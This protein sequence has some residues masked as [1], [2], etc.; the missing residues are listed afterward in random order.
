MTFPLALPGN[1]MEA[2][3]E[4]GF[5]IT[6]NVVSLGELARFGAALNAQGAERT[7]GN[8]RPVSEKHLRADLHPVHATL[9]N[10]SHPA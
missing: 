4:D 6:E 8:L 2:F 1:Q 10:E 7:S 9:V 5:V 3:S